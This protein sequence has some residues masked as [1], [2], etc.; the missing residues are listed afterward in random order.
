MTKFRN[1]LLFI[2]LFFFINSF[3][4]KL[5]APD[6]LASD[7]IV[8]PY[9][10]N[11]NQ[12]DVVS[13]GSSHIYCGINIDVLEQETGLSAYNLS[14]SS[15]KIVQ[16]YFLL[17]ESI[18]QEKIPKLIILDLFE[19]IR[20]GKFEKYDLGYNQIYK[21]YQGLQSES[22]K[23]EYKEV[24]NFKPYPLELS[25]IH[26]NWK[27]LSFSN[28]KI[29]LGF[30]KSQMSEEKVYKGFY[31]TEEKI[32]KEDLEFLIKGVNFDKIPHYF[33]I[34]EIND[35]E[36]YYLKKIIDISEDNNIKVLLIKTPVLN[37]IYQSEEYINKNYLPLRKKISKLNINYIDFNDTN[38]LSK[39]E[40]NYLEDFK[41]NGHLNINGSTKL[42]KYL[43]PVINSYEIKK[44]TVK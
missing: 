22:I 19:L 10:K 33:P 43:I 24:M 34:T 35:L 36:F 1:S 31:S 5:L 11:T 23:K 44:D 26:N 20:S 32:R 6:K 27:N 41:D 14:H 38:N 30:E 13:L 39:L 29:N 15:Q 16:S 4:C 8:R 42:T 21:T 7:L 28:L 17:K 9:F 37:Y 2:L 12:Y 25:N 40:L 18:E 3:F